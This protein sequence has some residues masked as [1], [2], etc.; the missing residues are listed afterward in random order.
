[1]KR[2]VSYFLLTGV[3]A[4]SLSSCNKGGDDLFD[5]EVEIDKEAFY[6][7]KTKWEQL[8]IKDYTFDCSFGNAN[9]S[10][11]TH[12]VVVRN[13]VVHE[14][15]PEPGN[16]YEFEYLKI[17]FGRNLTID[18]L[19]REIESLII[20]PYLSSAKDLFCHEINAIYDATYH[21]P[22]KVVFSFGQEGKDKDGYYFIQAP[23][24]IVN[25]TRFEV[26]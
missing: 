16:I 20:N 3:L 13:G 5:G 25:I 14:I 4:L 26:E 18:N 17:F 11:V 9:H 6:N 10:N 2:L 24:V 21:Y 22:K 12:T 1:M 7:T 19:L 8:N 23:D 15:T